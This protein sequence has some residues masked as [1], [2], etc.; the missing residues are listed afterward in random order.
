MSGVGSIIG[1]AGAFYFT[2]DP[3]AT[4]FDYITNMTHGVEKISIGIWWSTAL[5]GQTVLTRDQF[6]TDAKPQ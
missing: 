4:S 3:T 1:A 6:V 5:S 2:D